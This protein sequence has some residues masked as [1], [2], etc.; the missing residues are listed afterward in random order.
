MCLESVQA[1]LAHYGLKHFP[2]FQQISQQMEVDIFYNL[3]ENGIVRI[4]EKR[5]FSDLSASTVV[6]LP[7]RTAMD[8]T[9]FIYCTYIFIRFVAES[10]FSFK[11]CICLLQCHSRLL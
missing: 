5:N 1:L 2:F 6:Y 4:A 8:C 7:T 10:A 9:Y 11:Q 3:C